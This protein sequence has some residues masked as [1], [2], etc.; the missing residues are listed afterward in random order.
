MSSAT[1]TRDQLRYLSIELTHFLSFR[2]AKIELGD[3]V[4]LVGPNSSGK[5]NAMAAIKLLRDIPI[6]GLPV[7]IAR[8]GG[9]DQ[10]RHRSSGRPYDPGIRINFQFGDAKAS[11]YEIRLASLK[12]KQYEV[13][14][15]EAKIYFGADEYTFVR[16]RDSIHWRDLIDGKAYDEASSKRRVRVPPGQ[17]VIQFA[18][19]EAGFWVSRVLSLTQNVEINPSRVGEL[20]EPSSTREFEPDGSNLVSILE[21]FDKDERA[22]LIDYIQ[23]IVPGVEGYKIVHLAD[24]LSVAFV[25]NEGAQ[26]NREFLAK[27]MSDGTLRSFAIFVALLQPVR[28]RLLVVEEPEVAIHLGA[29]HT[30]VQILREYSADCQVIITTHSAD[31]IDDLDLDDIRVVWSEDGASHVSLVA[32]HSREPVRQG[33]ITPGALLRSDALD[34]L[35]A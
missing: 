34:P 11:F 5:S 12:G 35:S 21:L 8:R 23:S 14:R 13:K 3:F 6:H 19:S 4:A 2:E 24:K 25:Q 20:Q 1:G 9:F 32:E 27:Q 10:L 16:T 15:E 28:P 18:F 33:L 31:I 29:L 7:A 26:G 30:L 17:S 22:Q